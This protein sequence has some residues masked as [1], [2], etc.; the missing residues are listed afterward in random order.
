MLS[1]AA[2]IQPC[3]AE[4]RGFL[5][6]LVVSGA[7]DPVV[8]VHP[9]HPGLDPGDVSGAIRDGRRR[10]PS[11]SRSAGALVAALVRIRDRRALRYG[12]IA[13]GP[14]PRHGLRDVERAGQSPKSTPSSAS[15]S[16][17]T[18]SS[19]CSSIA[20][21][22][23]AATSRCSCCRCS[24]ASPSA[25]SKNGCSG[26]SPAA[27]ATC[28]T[29]SSMSRRSSAGCSSASASIRLMPARSDPAGL[30]PPHRRGGCG[31]R[32]AL[33][34]VR[35][36]GP[37]RRRDPRSGHGAV[38]LALRRCDARPHRQDRLVVWKDQP[39]IERPR[40]R[41]SEDQYMSEGLLHVHERNRRWE[42]A[43][44]ARRGQRT[45]FSRSTMRR[46]STRPRTS[47]A[48]VTAGPPAAACGR[49]AAPGVSA[50]RRA[51]SRAAPTSPRDATSSACGRRPCSGWSSCWGWQ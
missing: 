43:D 45:S 10:R 49:R 24:P 6:A 44:M 7:V 50:A 9:R 25:R 14:G 32:A 48:P 21:G 16:S 8:A 19:R 2:V 5:L 34:D 11:P 18:A 35:L 37:P 12:A 51:R 39:P 27:S 17:S 30:A 23:R 46:S 4:P 15:T 40:S 22:G 3:R 13:L 28:A 31:R 1:R 47:R 36:L 29:C 42:A 33:R 41:S 38:P 26:S 20:S